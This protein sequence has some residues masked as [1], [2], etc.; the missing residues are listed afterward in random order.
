MLIKILGV[1]DLIIGLILIF[2][3]NTKLHYLFLLVLAVILI[4]KA[5]MGSL[6]GFA[7]WTDLFGG[8]IFVLL[9]FFSIPWI[10]CLIVG[11][12]LIQK[13]VVSFL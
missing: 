12:L 3:G 13:G 6:Q 9:I 1:V 8:I 4:L 2:L 10:I 7:S 11:I 5:V